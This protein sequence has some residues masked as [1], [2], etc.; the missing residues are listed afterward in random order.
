MQAKTVAHTTGGKAAARKFTWRALWSQRYM[1]AMSV[2]FVLWLFVFRYY[3]LW[4]WTMAFQNYK[5]SKGFFEQTWVGLSQFRTLF[6]EADFYLALR[7][8]L[9][10]SVMGLVFGFI[11]P[12]LFALMLNEVRGRRFKR[13]V[14]TV[15]YLPHF[16][17]WVIASNM[18]VQLLS[19]DG[20]LVNNVLMA[21]GILKTPV[22][23]MAIP[24]AFWWIVTL[25]DVWKETGWNSI[26]YIAAIA[27]IDPSLYEAATVDGAGRL[28]R[29]WHVTLPGIR[30]T[31]SVI[32]IMNI[33]WLLNIGF[34]RQMLL[35]NAVVQEYMLVLDYYTLNYGIALGR[36]SYGTAI[37]IF[38]SVVSIVLLLIANNVAKRIGEGQVI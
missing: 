28:R 3:P 21:L 23:F 31:I 6:S 18:I 15:S 19:I 25:A 29:I 14:Q 33:G 8:T 12:I 10:M 9:A 17:S 30:P 24:K 27:G 2:P 26:I 20:G 35:G 13:T 38:K 7:N 16:I 34:E 1:L 32:L 11:M 22:Q 5:P 36:Y 4:G 37:G